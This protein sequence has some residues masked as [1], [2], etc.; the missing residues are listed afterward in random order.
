MGRIVEVYY[1]DLTIRHFYSKVQYHHKVQPFVSVLFTVCHLPVTLRR[2][3]SQVTVYHTSPRSKAR[4]Y[5]FVSFL[6]GSCQINSLAHIIGSSSVSA[7]IPEV[8]SR[9]IRF[10]DV[11]PPYL[12]TVLRSIGLCFEQ[13]NTISGREHLSHSQSEPHLR[14]DARQAPT[15]SNST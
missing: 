5:I 13:R 3:V 2:T 14:F 6:F 15:S 4:E 11:W 10:D 9:C 7:L 12:K 1:S 8:L